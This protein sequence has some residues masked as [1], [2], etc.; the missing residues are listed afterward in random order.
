MWHDE[1][2]SAVCSR[3]NGLR[4]ISLVRLRD[5]CRSA[6][7]ARSAAADSRW[8]RDRAA[9]GT[10]SRSR[11]GPSCCC[12]FVIEWHDVHARPACASGVSICSL[13]GWSKRPLKNTAWSW[14]P[15]HHFDGCVPIDVL[16]VLDRLAV[17][18][19]VE[20]REVV[21]RR[22][23]L[24]V[25]VLVAAAARL[26]LVMKNF[27]GIVRCTLVSEARRKERARRAGAFFVHRPSAESSDSRSG[28]PRRAPR[29]A[30]RRRRRT[31]I[32]LPRRR[33]CR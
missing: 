14:Q 11:P 12:T 27:D 16:H 33:G 13:I 15:A 19:V 30:S 8:R 17:P 9:A 5:R 3:W 21:R 32:P 25:D 23:P 10:R 18:L 1:Q 6:G 4:N 2:N 28:R 29:D 20:R 22:L 31:P 7:R 24:L 26:S